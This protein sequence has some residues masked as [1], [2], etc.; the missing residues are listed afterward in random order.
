M[1]LT[2]NIDLN[3]IIDSVREAIENS[4]MQDDIA[5]TVRNGLDFEQVAEEIVGLYSFERSIESIVED[6]V[7]AAVGEAV[8]DLGNRVEDME[9]LLRKV[10]TVIS[11]TL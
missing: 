3:E 9:R 11:D 4:S 10:S 5:D 7:V 2:L 1:E 8:S 6:A